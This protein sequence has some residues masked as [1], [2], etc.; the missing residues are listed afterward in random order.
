MLSLPAVQLGDLAEES[1]VSHVGGIT[2]RALSGGCII[3]HIDIS[4]I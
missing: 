2:A 3:S 4:Y 1:V